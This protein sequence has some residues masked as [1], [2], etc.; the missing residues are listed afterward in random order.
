[1]PAVTHTLGTAGAASMGVAGRLRPGSGSDSTSCRGRCRRVGTTKLIC[2]GGIAILTIPQAPR[3]CKVPLASRVATRASPHVY[4]QAAGFF[5]LQQ[6]SLPE[7][8]AKIY[9]SNRRSGAKT[10]YPHPESTKI[11]RNQ[12]WAHSELVRRVK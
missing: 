11:A 3:P 12:D 2:S 10:I 7:A 9:S 4:C 5:V 6:F 1:M 8:L